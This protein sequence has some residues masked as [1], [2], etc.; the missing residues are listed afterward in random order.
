M[1][2]MARSL[3]AKTGRRIGIKKMARSLKAKTGRRIGIV[4]TAPSS[5]HLAPF[6][7]SSWE[8][9]LMGPAW[10]DEGKPM[11]WDEWFE[12]HHVRDFDPE[13]TTADPGYFEWL[14]QQTKPVHMLS[15]LD[16][17]IKTAVAFPSERI[18]ARHGGFFL[19]STIPWMMAYIHDELADVEEVGFWGV[20]FASDEERRS[21]KKGW[22][23]FKKLLEAKGIKITVPPESDMSYEASPYGL[24]SYASQKLKTQRKEYEDRAAKLREIVATLEAN[25]AQHKV[26]IA[27]LDAAISTIDWLETLH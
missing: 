3:K 6:S 12:L 18:L 1:K 4:G 25:T 13:I 9:W 15:P 27:R 19:D 10:Q 17:R 16:P 11:R 22:Y 8:F 14:S 20:D 26:D 24:P 5:R 7:D 2:K 21:Q 23:H